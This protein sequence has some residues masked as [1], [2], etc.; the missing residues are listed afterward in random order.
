MTFR[1]AKEPVIHAIYSKDSSLVDD[2]QMAVA[3]RGDCDDNDELVH[4]FIDSKRKSFFRN[5]T[6]AKGFDITINLN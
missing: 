5:L 4:K 6:T 3:N 1:F 2:F